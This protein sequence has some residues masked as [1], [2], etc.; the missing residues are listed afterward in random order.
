MNLNAPFCEI[1]NDDSFGEWKIQLPMQIIFI[2]SND[3]RETCTM[4]T[5]RQ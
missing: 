2:S 3:S 1:T 4:D 5:K